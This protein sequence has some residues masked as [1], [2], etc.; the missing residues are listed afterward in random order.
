V[1]VLKNW[2]LQP[3]GFLDWGKTWDVGD[4]AIG[5]EDPTQGVRA[6]RMNI[7]FGFGKRFDVPGLGK[8]PNVRVYAAHPVGEGSDGN[9]W[10]VLLGFEK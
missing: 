4:N 7:G 3:I 2:M 8:F 9:G 6:W 10:R 5:L 1:P